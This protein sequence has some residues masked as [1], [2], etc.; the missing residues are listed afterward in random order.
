MNT[1]IDS[2]EF[3]YRIGSYVDLCLDN[4]YC[5]WWRRYSD[6]WYSCTRRNSKGVSV[7]KN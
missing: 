1:V 3:A 7:C 6:D 2:E 5:S 4:S